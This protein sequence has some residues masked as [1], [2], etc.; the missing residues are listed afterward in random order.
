MTSETVRPLPASPMGVARLSL[1]DALRGFGLFGVLMINLFGHLPGHAV[2]A[3]LVLMVA[4]LWLGRAAVLRE[5]V[6]HRRFWQYLL[7]ASLALGLIAAAG[8]S[9]APVL[10][11]VALLPLGAFLAASFVLLFQRAAWRRW[12]QKLAPTGR[13]ALTNG[14]AQALFSLCLLHGTNLTFDPMSL[15]LCGVAIFALQAASSCW[16]LARYSAGPA[17][18]LCHSLVS[19]KPQPMCR[20]TARLDHRHADVLVSLARLIEAALAQGRSVMRSVTGGA[21]GLFALM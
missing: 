14:V 11:D 7:R 6:A 19:R 3:L 16:W 2:S 17:E 18:W 10:R 4:S 20:R 12:L 8:A 15:L 1:P 5:S 13:M 9:A 21:S